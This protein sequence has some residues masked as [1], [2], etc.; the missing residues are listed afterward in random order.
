MS[1][2]TIL[3]DSGEVGLTLEGTLYPCRPSYEA[4]VAIEQQLGVAIDELW[5]KARRLAEALQDGGVP[6]GAGFK[7]NEMAVIITECVKAAGRERE[8]ANLKLWKSE[9]VAKKLAA[10][11]FSANQ[12]VA[13]LLTNMLFG[14]ADPKKDEAG[15]PGA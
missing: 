12:P 9:T 6:H 3:A 8:D 10:D 2:Y 14:G 1:E 15:S 5:L 4:Q 11:R 7:L 13:E